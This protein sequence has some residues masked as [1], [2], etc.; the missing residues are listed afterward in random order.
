MKTTA[1]SSASPHYL[2]YHIWNQNYWN[3]AFG[4]LVGTKAMAANRSGD[5]AYQ[6]VTSF[7]SL[8]RDFFFVALSVCY[9]KPKTDRRAYLS[10]FPEWVEEWRRC[11]WS[12]NMRDA[13]KPS[14]PSWWSCCTEWSVAQPRF[15]GTQETVPWSFFLSLGFRLTRST[16]FGST[17]INYSQLRCLLV[18]I[19]KF[20]A[21]LLWFLPTP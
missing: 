1:L 9:L 3:F 17:W 13:R 18:K 12:D 4:R 8:G 7:A 5:R 6:T 16:R 20:I 21:A 15:A 19:P 11:I 10:T 14:I 2:K